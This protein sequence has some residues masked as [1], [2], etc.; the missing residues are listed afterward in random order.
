MC[1]SKNSLP[2]RNLR[3]SPTLPLNTGDNETLVVV[4]ITLAESAQCVQ[5][6]RHD[7][8]DAG[9]M[10]E[11][12]DQTALAAPEALLEQI[13]KQTRKIRSSRARLPRYRSATPG[14]SF[15]RPNTSRTKALP[16]APSGPTACTKNEKLEPK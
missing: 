5:A 14:A 7:G 9:E 3:E 15:C 4:A 2:L 11:G 10:V 13:E 6:D 12:S 16:A 8:V 1:F